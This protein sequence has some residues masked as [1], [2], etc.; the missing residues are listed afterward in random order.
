MLEFKNERRMNVY[1]SG[2]MRLEGHGYW[3]AWGGVS[4]LCCRDALVRGQLYSCEAE[5][6][7]TWESTG[8]IR[9]SRKVAASRGA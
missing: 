4:C 2:K 9:L 5:G 1:V 3:T 8:E 7:D 6:Q